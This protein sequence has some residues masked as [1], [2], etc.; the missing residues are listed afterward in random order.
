MKHKNN[1]MIYIVRGP[2]FTR[3]ILLK[4]MHS[5]STTY[6]QQYLSSTDVDICEINNLMGQN[7]L[8]TE[9]KC[10]RIRV[11]FSI[12]MG[13]IRSSLSTVIL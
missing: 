10:K 7:V 5:T 6:I 1:D 11:A 12:V 3:T 4:P 8:K 2:N 13:L 9:L